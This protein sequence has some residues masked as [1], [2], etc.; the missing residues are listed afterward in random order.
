MKL[1]SSTQAVAAAVGFLLQFAE[2]VRNSM[3][4]HEVEGKV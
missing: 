3:A 4:L 1:S 2:A